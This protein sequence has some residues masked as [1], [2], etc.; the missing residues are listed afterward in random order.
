MLDIKENKE[1]NMSN[2]SKF[3]EVIAGR[4]TTTKKDADNL[5]VGITESLK[6]HLKNEGEAVLPGFGRLRLVT[7]PAR[8]GHNPR[9]RETITIG[10]HQVVKFK[11]FPGALD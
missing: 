8:T 4:L 1:K 9:T 11:A 6:D 2:R 5:L 3:A 10:E 7:R